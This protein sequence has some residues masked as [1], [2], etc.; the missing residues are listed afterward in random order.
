MSRPSVSVVVPLYNH[1]KYIAAALDSVLCQSLPAAE[2]IVV[3]DGSTDGSAA[4]VER[5]ARSHQQIRL[6]RHP[7]QG[8]HYTINT[9]IHLASGQYVA[10]LNSDD[11]YAP[12]RLRECA[13]IL[14]AQHDVTA[15]ATGL[16]FMDDGGRPLRNAWYEGARAFYEE[17]GDLALALANGN[18][19]MTTSNLVL[20]RS[21]FAEAGYFSGL[22]YAHDLD[23]LLRLLLTGKRIHLIDRPLMR[24][25]LHA[26]NTIKED[27][28]KVRAEWASVVAYF[29][30]S[31]FSRRPVA[32]ETWL[33]YQRL[34]QV[35]ERHQLTKLIF[36][37]LGFFQTLPPGEA[38]SEAFLRHP[39]FRQRIMEIA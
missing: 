26:A 12:H 27:G 32:A 10:I 11:A 30:Y 18:F 19:I 2:I 1:E 6:W 20:C 33:Y 21:V 14:A 4:I 16:E 3:D 28:L 38:S 9:G 8:A 15:V 25:R 24:Y 34:L 5:Y 29:A 35:A 22:R 39:E 17:A 31:L 13:G 36:M 7:N 23:F 37:F